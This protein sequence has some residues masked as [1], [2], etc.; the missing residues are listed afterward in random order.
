MRAPRRTLLPLSLAA[1]LLAACSL[2]PDS[3]PTQDDVNLETLVAGVPLTERAAQMLTPPTLAP[4]IPPTAADTLV[5]T[6]TFTPAPTLTTTRP[7]KDPRWKFGDP[8]WTDNFDNPNNWSPYDGEYSKVEIAGGKF[9]FTTYA[10]NSKA[11]WIVSW[12]TW[13]NF[14]LEITAQTPVECSGKDRYGVIFRA[15][16]PSE[17]YLFNLSCDG[18]YRLVAISR[19]GVVILHNWTADP[20]ILAG[21][22]Q[23]NRLGM[24]ANGTVIEIYANGIRLVGLH[25]DTYKQ[26]GTI[27]LSIASENTPNFTVVFDDLAFWNI[28]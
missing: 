21:P 1:L 14:Y 27:G 11:Y 15:P 16:N 7:P 25:D 24:W 10:N 12:P 22:N 13:G 18:Q 23:V 4:T 17:G 20:A 19:D 8:E 28:R 3:S 9:F 6:R 5:P 2:N 26:A